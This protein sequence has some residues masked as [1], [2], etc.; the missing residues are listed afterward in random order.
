[1]R[2]ILLFVVFVLC[3]YGCGYVKPTENQRELH[4]QTIGAAEVAAEKSTDP[5]GKQAAQ[6]AAD[7]AKLTQKVLIGE[8]EVKKPYSHQETVKV[9]TIVQ[10]EYDESKAPW[11]KRWAGTL[12]TGL[13]IL[14]GI[15]GFA[16]RFFPAA[17]PI[18]AAIQVANETVLKPVAAMLTDVK[19]SADAHPSDAL[20]LDVITSKIS[21]LTQIPG[22]GPLLLGLLE[23]A[24]MTAAVHAPEGAD[25]APTAAPAA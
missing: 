18:A 13:T 12:M 20:P 24:H 7:T 16:G 6:D 1:M 2:T 21:A 3:L 4:Q 25:P 10:K 9:I 11:Y 23:K 22:V 5:A 14:V 8:P 15:A 17:A 19:I